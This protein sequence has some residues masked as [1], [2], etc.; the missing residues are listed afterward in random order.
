M[1][2]RDPQVQKKALVVLLPLALAVAYQQFYYG[3]RVA[4]I[5]RQEMRLE[6]L[7]RQ[8]NVMRAAVARYGEDL[9]RRLAIFREHLAQ[10]EQLIP[11]REDVPHLINQI[12]DVAGGTGVEL[13]VLRPGGETA[14]DHYNRQTYEL[15]VTGDY[16]SVAEYLTTIGSMPRIVRSA[17]VTLTRGTGETARGSAQLR[18][19]FRI[20]TYVMPAPGDEPASPAEG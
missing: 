5:E 16:H 15:E 11:N 7:N 4:E 8:N 18:A 1:N 14:G 13:T 10:L 17:N 2:L 6:A 3:D 12:A 9:E 19:R 20:D